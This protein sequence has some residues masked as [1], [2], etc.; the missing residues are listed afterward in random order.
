[1]TDRRAVVL[2]IGD[3]LL[4]GEIVDTNSSYLDALLEANGWRVVR[5][6]TVPDETAAI[7]AAFREAA[8]QGSLV[9][10][11]GGMGPTID[12]LT[13]TGLADAAGVELALN[14]TALEALEARFARNGWTLSPNNRRQ[15]MLPEGAEALVNEVGSAPAVKMPLGPAVVF[16]M[17]G[18]PSEL[19]WLMTHRVLP[20][21]TVATPAVRRRLLKTMGIGESRLETVLKDIIDIHPKVRVGFRTLGVENHVK[22]AAFGPQAVE[23]LDAIETDIRACLG[24]DVFG[25]DE[26]TL[27]EALASVLIDAGHTVATAESCTGGLIAKRLTDRPGSSA[28][29][30]GGVVAYANAV[31]TEMLGVEADLI[32]A[33][34]AVSEA[35]AARMAV[36]VRRRLHSDWGVSATGVA[37]PGGGTAEKPVGTVWVALAGPQGVRA[38]CLRRG[39]DR[40]QVRDATAKIAMHW[41]LNAVRASTS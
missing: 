25:R 33:N 12:D 3:E 4:S 20:R 29:M 1:M 11:T 30:L 2:S 39:G 27:T 41:L 21:L 9:L 7:A 15:A 18:V 6:L 16:C 10:S 32:E 34:G 36:G 26:Q 19:R 13:L 40:A 22:L 8:T 14:K 31:K 35:V 5:H 28:Y 37:G 38:R 17:P 24:E 23:D